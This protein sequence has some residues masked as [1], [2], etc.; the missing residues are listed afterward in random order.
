[1]QYMCIPV[2]KIFAYH[3]E[4]VNSTLAKEPVLQ[5]TVILPGSVF[6]DHGIIQ[7]VTAQWC[8]KRCFSYHMYLVPKEVELLDAIAFKDV[9][10]LYIFQYSIE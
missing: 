1:M 6:I 3:S 2:P 9:S 7:R 8:S 10:A 5:H 4:S